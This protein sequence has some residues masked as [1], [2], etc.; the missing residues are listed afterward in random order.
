[1]EDVDCEGVHTDMSGRRAHENATH[2][3]A[4]TAEMKEIYGGY[5]LANSLA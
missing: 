5:M 2:H 1:M 3:L 4:G